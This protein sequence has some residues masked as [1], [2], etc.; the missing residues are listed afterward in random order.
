[1]RN[2]LYQA[3]G[4][5]RGAKEASEQ[6]NSK[7][8]KKSRKI[9]GRACRQYFLNASICPVPCHFLKYHFLCQNCKMSRGTIVGGFHMLNMFVRLCALWSQII[10]VGVKQVNCDNWPI[11]AGYSKSWYWKQFFNTGSI[12][13]TLP[14]PHMVLPN[15]SQSAFL[16]IL[17]P[18]TG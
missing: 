15:F 9:K 13:L 10:D 5:C 18:G 6:W 11:I 2:S 7:W 8:V 16:T 3:H 17:E 4:Q 1:M 14:S 12:S